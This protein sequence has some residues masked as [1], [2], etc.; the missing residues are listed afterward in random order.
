MDEQTLRQ[1][2]TGGETSTVEFKRNAAR[3]IEVAIRMCGMANNRAG[4]IIIF[5][6]EDAT[7]AIVGVREPS[8]TIDVALRAARMAKPAVPLTETNVRTWTLDGRTLI[9]VEIPP[10]SGRLFQYDGAARTGVH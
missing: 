1:L 10:N 2:I 6:V 5:G 3:P 4:G 7:R 8:V 9:T